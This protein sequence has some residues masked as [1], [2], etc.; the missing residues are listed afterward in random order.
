M[1]NDVILAGGLEHEFYFPFIYGIILPIDFH[2]CQDG[3]N[4]QPGKNKPNCYSLHHFS[5]G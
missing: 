4:H 1:V 3:E 5:E 2:I